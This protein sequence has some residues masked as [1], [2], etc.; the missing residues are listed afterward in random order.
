MQSPLRLAFP[1]ESSCQ[2]HDKNAKRPI[3]FPI[4]IASGVIL[5]AVLLSCG[6]L[7]SSCGGGGRSSDEMALDPVTLDDVVFLDPQEHTVAREGQGPVNTSLIQRIRLEFSGP[8]NPGHVD[9]E[10]FQVRHRL[11]GIPVPG[12]FVF[13]RNNRLV[14]FIPRFPTRP[15]ER[16]GTLWSLDAGLTPGEEYEVIIPIGLPDALPNLER[17]NLRFKNEF[18]YEGDGPLIIPFMTTAEPTFFWTGLNPRTPELVAVDPEPGT[19]NF[20]LGL[21]DDK[22]KGRSITLRF[23]A[24]LDPSP[25]NVSTDVMR[26]H[27][28]FDSKG[29]AM[30]RDLAVKVSIVENTISG[31]TVLLEPVGILPPDHELAVSIPTMLR[32]LGASTPVGSLGEI[33]RF[34]TISIDANFE[35]DFLE[36]FETNRYEEREFEQLSRGL[37][38]A[39]WDK[40]NSNQLEAVI[41]FPGQGAVSYTH[42]TL[43][44]ILRV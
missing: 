4:R 12:S 22:D 6:G 38:P 20:P 42:L 39:A 37:V 43:P 3:R 21:V 14:T 8:I 11:S 23:N 41:N 1:L 13:Q 19:R 30:E 40:D 9:T 25:D 18:N 10:S 17:F 33:T 2:K 34:T 35:T 5:G 7:L 26:L 36:D 31:S 32:G 28:R 29:R 15:V 16:D 44:T 27:D 24:P